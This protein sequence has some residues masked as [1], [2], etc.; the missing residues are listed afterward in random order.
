MQGQADLATVTVL[1]S[2]A[3]ASTARTGPG[4]LGGLRAGLDAL[5]V[6]GR[7]AAV[8]VGALVP[9]VPVLLL[10]GVAARALRG[11]WPRRPAPTP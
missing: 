9:F 11:R 10:V 5:L 2:S 7:A 8:A 6:T 4:F 1:L 3:P